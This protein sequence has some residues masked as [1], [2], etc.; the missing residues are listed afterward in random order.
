[1]GKNAFIVRLFLGQLENLWHFPARKQRANCNQRLALER[2]ALCLALVLSPLLLAAGYFARPALSAERKPDAAG[3]ISSPLSE[4]KQSSQTAPGT[5]GDEFAGP[6]PTWLDLKRDFGAKGDGLFDDTPAL[7]NALDALS[8][9]KRGPALWIPAGTYRVTKTLTLAGG[10]GLSIVGDS[11]ATTTFKWSGPKGGTLLHIDGVAYSRFDRLS[12]DGAKTAGVLVDQ[13]A[14]QFGGARVFDTGNEYADDVFEDASIGIQGGQFDKGAAETSVLRSKFLRLHGGIAL[15]NFNALD[16]WVWNSYFEANDVGITNNLDEHGA[17]NFHAFG[18]VFKGSKFADLYILNTGQFNFR[19]NYSTGSTNFLIE[20]YFYTNAAVTDVQRNTIIIPP[21]NSCSGCGIYMG[22]MGPLVLTDNIFISPPDAKRAAV[23]VRS[24]APPDC[25]SV[26][27]TYTFKDQIYCQGEQG[28]GRLLSV[29]DKVVAAASVVTKMPPMPVPPARA[30]RPIY[31][32]QVHANAVALQSLLDKAASRCG[33]RPIIHL[34]RGVYYLDRTLVFPA[35]CPLQLVGDGDQP[36]S[37]TVLFWGG[38]RSG[39]ALRLRGPSKTVLKEL[40]VNAQ[41]STG[42]EIAGADQ[43]G[44]RI[45]GEQLKIT[46]ATEADLFI[47]RLDET[48]VELHDFELAYTAVPPA[49]GGVALKVVGGPRAQKGESQAGRVNLLAGS[50]AA[51]FQTVDVSGGGSVLLRDYWYEATTPSVF[52]KVAGDSRVTFEG[53]RIAM[54]A[55]GTALQIDGLH[56]EATVLSSALDVP[57]TIQTLRGGNVWAA[58]SNFGRAKTWWSDKGGSEGSAFSLNRH[59]TVEGSSA[60]PDVNARPD[61]SFVRALLAQA[62]AARPS[63]INDLP[64]NLTDVRMY[65]V[66]INLGRVGVYIGP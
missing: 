6:F 47:D 23:Y 59:V 46:H 51:N 48:L 25:L 40:A 21:G 33:E 20:K 63:S 57:I 26:G 38:G 52:A 30:K 64:N 49:T 24:L 16:W 41:G 61:A 54:P 11:P 37:G 18:N 58:G 3:S 50:G 28:P 15:R 56:G 4:P 60:V 34:P 10:I 32:A 5:S 8:S 9:N 44:A 13:S 19:D 55:E 36:Q 43:P 2:P 35:N 53:S 39:P 27:N 12:F 66:S 22:N 45:F 1:M 31:E 17:G 14:T 65:R 7:Q 42:I 29:D 62:R